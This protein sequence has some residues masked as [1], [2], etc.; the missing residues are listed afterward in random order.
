MKVKDLSIK[1]G[2]RI[3]QLRQSQR[4][5]QEELAFKAG[6]STAH[7]GQIERA[8]KK[9]TLETIGKLSDALGISLNQLFAFEESSTSLPGE[10]ESAVIAKINAHLMNMEIDEQKDVLRIIRIFHRYTKQKQNDDM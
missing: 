10:S 5:S 6:I 8:E 3:R 2:K 7:L 1:F 4:M 9:P